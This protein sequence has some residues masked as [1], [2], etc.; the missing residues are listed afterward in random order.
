MSNT[1]TAADTDGSSCD[2]GQFCTQV[3]TCASGICGG[4]GDPCP[5][6]DADGDNA[7][8]LGGVDGLSEERHANGGEGG[9]DDGG[10]DGVCDRNFE[11]SQR[12][13]EQHE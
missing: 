10:P 3:D 2:D 5:G 6:A 9:H 13:V 8:H 11:G 4:T 12:D 1:C 7:D